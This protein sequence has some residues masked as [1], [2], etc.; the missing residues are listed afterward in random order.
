MGKWIGRVLILLR[1]AH[2]DAYRLM[3]GMPGAAGEILSRSRV[4]PG[5]ARSPRM[6]AAASAPCLG[7][8]RGVRRLSLLACV[9]AER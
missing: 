4:M 8:L 3:K 1:T 7:L 9:Q 5:P 6:P 2:A